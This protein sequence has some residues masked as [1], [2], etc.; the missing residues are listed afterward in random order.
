MED[1]LSACSFTFFCKSLLMSFKNAWIWWKFQA[2][3]Q[4]LVASITKSIPSESYLRAKNHLS[5]FKKIHLTPE[6]RSLL[7]SISHPLYAAP[8][9]KWLHE[10]Y[11]GN[12]GCV[13]QVDI[14]GMWQVLWKAGAVMGELKETFFLGGG[15]ENV[16]YPR[17]S[18]RFALSHRPPSPPLSSRSWGVLSTIHNAWSPTNP[19]PP[20]HAQAC[21]G[22]FP[23]TTQPN[24]TFS[25]K[26]M[27][28]VA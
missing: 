20:H 12:G 26:R 10:F 28:A 4:K 2:S 13:L 25:P 23:S 17:A 3:K 11:L 21:H 27:R 24:S 5:H 18:N 8:A 16:H 19:P 7:Q 22:S 1:M 14:L 6:K 15:G 9:A